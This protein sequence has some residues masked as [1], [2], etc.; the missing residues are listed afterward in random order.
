M[1]K[2]MML[3]SAL[4][5]T[6][7]MM[8]SNAAPPITTKVLLRTTLSGDSSKEV[9]MA[10]AEIAEGGSTGVHTHPGDE[11]ATVLE[12]TLEIHIAGQVVKR[13]QA[14]ESYHNAKGVV[15]ESKNS[16]AGKVRIVSTFVIDKGQ[17]MMQP[18]TH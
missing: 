2:L 4:A 14:G 18:A 3:G 16:G 6:V 13:V 8:S 7:W 15:H 12:G 1:K 10:T 9:I 17:P 11:Y 5:A